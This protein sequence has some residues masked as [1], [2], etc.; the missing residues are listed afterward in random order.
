MCLA[1]PGRIVERLPDEGGLPFALVELDGLR[2]PVCLACV[3]EASPGQFV[4]V[5]AGL[6]ISLLDEA[7]AE[8]LLTDLRAM[9]AGP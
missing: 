4:I 2:Q 3:P 5:H 7:E 6:A 9:G 8:R 1:V